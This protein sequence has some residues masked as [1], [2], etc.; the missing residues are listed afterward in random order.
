M[1]LNTYD[2]LTAAKRLDASTTI[3]LCNFESELV[4]RIKRAFWPASCHSVYNERNAT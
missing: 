1:T 2:I 4:K 3:F